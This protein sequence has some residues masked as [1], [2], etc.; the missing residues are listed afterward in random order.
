[1]RRVRDIR[2]GIIGAPTN[3]DR[4]NPAYTFEYYRF[5][6]HLSNAKLI[7][8][9]YVG[10]SINRT[11]AYGTAEP[12]INTPVLK[13]GACVSLFRWESDPAP[14]YSTYY[15]GS[16]YKLIFYIGLPD[17]DNICYLP[18]FTPTAALSIDTKVD[19]GLPGSGS[20]MTLTPNWPP[21]ANCAT[22][23]DPITARYKTSSTALD[24]NLMFPA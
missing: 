4:Q 9:S 10:G 8:G 15:S 7:P 14:L 17:P 13:N 2:D 3:A 24:C 21:T 16:Y 18:A 5:W 23:S 20:V 19:D 11:D 22:T 1:M 6:Q 12:G